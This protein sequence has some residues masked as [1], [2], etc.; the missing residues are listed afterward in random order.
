MEILLDG[1]LMTG[2]EAVHDLLAEK[3]NFPSYY[4]RNLD[5]LYDLLTQQCSDL[6]I[7]VADISVIRENL[8]I[9]A[10]ALFSTMEDAAAYNPFLT[11]NFCE[12][13]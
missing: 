11:V 6:K 1:R 10:T 9:Y 4:G 5:A 7:T 12:N 13:F 3:L 2:R 8:G